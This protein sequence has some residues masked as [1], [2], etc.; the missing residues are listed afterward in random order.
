MNDRTGPATTAADIALASARV[1]ALGHRLPTSADHTSDSDSNGNGSGGNG[2]DGNASGDNGGGSSNN[3]GSNPGS[4]GVERGGGGG[5][6]GAGIRSAARGSAFNLVGAATAAIAGFVTVGLIT[7]N[8][9][10][11]GAGLFFTATAVFT[12]AANGTRLGGETALTLFVSRF[13]AA[14]RHRELAPLVRTATTATGLSA[15]VLGLVGLAAAPWLAGALTADAA[16]ADELTV[17]IRILAVAVPAF[18]LSQV[19]FG[20]SRGYGTMRPSVMVGQLFRPIAQLVLVVVVVA[21]ST[22]TWPLALAWAVASVVAAVAIAGWLWQRIRRSTRSHDAGTGGPFDAGDY[23]RFAGPRAV[24]DLVASALERLDVL[25][26]ALL[27][28]AADAGLY[29]ASN[30]LILAGQLLLFAT[31]QSMAPLL[32]AA[33][34]ERRHADAKRLLTTITTWSVFVLWPLLLAL[35]F[36]A[37]TVLAVFG[38]GFADAAPVVRVLALALATIVALGPGDIVLLMTGESVASLVNHIAALLV[39]VVVSVVLL[40]QVG[41]I[42][43]AWAWASSRLTLRV[44]AGFQVWRAT[45]VHTFGWGVGTAAVAAVACFVPTGFIA[46]RMIDTGLLALVSHL[47]TGG[48]L[49]LALAFV[50]RDRLEL[51]QLAGVLTR[52]P[53]AAP[54]ARP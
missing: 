14:D 15:V 46:Y 40:P 52:R 35:A 50:V 26:V 45:G 19:L 30:R 32:S 49:Y 11:A 9:G 48:L 34:L 47:A 41:L 6:D 38:D 5:R 36:G 22:D 28:T 13:R 17:M 29:G 31:S 33:F 21:V 4:G 27:L 2:S 20:A 25:L 1:V 42:G 24:T 43:A 7:N 18:A 53:S 12:L 39:L 37:E 44:A 51:D 16:N 54:G 8:Y 3:G 10:Q 23:W